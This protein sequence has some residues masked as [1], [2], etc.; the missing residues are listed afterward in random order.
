MHILGKFTVSFAPQTDEHAGT[1][2]PPDHLQ[3]I[4]IWMVGRA[5][6]ILFDWNVIL[7]QIEQVTFV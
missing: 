3:R 7:V 2:S 4:M 5:S 6:Y 1:N